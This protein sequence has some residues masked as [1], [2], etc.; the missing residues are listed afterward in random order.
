MSYRTYVNNIQLF[1][2]NDCFE[3]WLKYIK[4]QGIKVDGNYNYN[5]FITDID[6]A[7]N[8]LEEIVMNIENKNNI[9]KQDSDSYLLIN[10]SP[11]LIFM[12]D[13][14]MNVVE[15]S[16]MFLPVQFINCCGNL[17]KR[18]LSV[19]GR[20]YNYVVKDGMKINVCA[21]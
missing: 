8:A 7:L 4:S 10:V 16:Y 20:L 9:L 19:D 11:Y 15:N 17:I 2:N 14:L 21:Y 1:G 3:P 5:G 6:G 12:T 13:K 18:N